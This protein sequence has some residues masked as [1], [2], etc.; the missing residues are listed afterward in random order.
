MNPRRSW[1]SFF[2]TQ[3]HVNLIYFVDAAKTKTI[4]V[5]MRSA[6]IFVASSIFL[7]VWAVAAG[8][9]IARLQAK[10]SDLRAEL[11]SSRAVIFEYQTLH[12]GVFEQAYPELKDRR[13]AGAGSPTAASSQ[14]SQPVLALSAAAPGVQG[15]KMAD[16]LESAKT[17]TR[18][19]SKSPLSLSNPK[20]IRRKSGLE[21][22]F[23]LRN[24]DASTKAEGV[25]WGVA[26][27]ESGNGER[28]TVT[29]PR[30]LSL[31]GTG[32][33]SNPAQ[34]QR[35]GIR[36]YARRSFVFP[37]PEAFDGK[38]LTV[39]IALAGNK[40]QYRSAYT[41]PVNMKFS[42]VV[43]HDPPVKEESADDDVAHDP[44]ANTED[45]SPADAPPG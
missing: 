10:Q 25:I 42:E 7:V 28:I 43:K 32:D 6:T 27:M 26:A 31:N 1:K 4:R 5:T 40:G 33:P 36:R 3:R 44:S 22:F 19:D 12:D 15:K 16:A 14:A 30:N 23:D 17:L 38:V 37:V 45:P 20:F 34:G 29:V 2:S 21:V 39:E 41:I 35:F 11:N 13:F 18:S 8:G 24:S 9:W